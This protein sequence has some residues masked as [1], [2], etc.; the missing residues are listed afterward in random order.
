MM[1]EQGL[2]GGISMVSKQYAHANNLYEW[3]MFSVPNGSNQIEFKL[4]LI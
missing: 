2:R 3:A 4:N 1:I